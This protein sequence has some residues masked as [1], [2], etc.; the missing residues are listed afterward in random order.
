MPRNT[1]KVVT[2]SGTSEGFHVLCTDLCGDNPRTVCTW[3]SHH[4]LTTQYHIHAVIFGLF[5]YCMFAAECQ[6]EVN[7]RQSSGEPPSSIPQ[8]AAAAAS[9]E[10]RCVHTHNPRSPL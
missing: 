7:G 2:C 4:D 9:A 5:L 6:E 8:A 3:D 1:V 10:L